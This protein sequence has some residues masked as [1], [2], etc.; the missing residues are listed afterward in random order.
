[1]NLNLDEVLVVASNKMGHGDDKLG[2][3]LIKSFIHVLAESEKL[4]GTILFY[5]SGVLLAAENSAC[6][7]DLKSIEKKGAELLLCGTCADY[8]NITDK[9]STGKISNMKTILGKMEEAKK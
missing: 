6:L 1:V 5:N 8:Y 7:D 3:I 9:I 2:E 4:P